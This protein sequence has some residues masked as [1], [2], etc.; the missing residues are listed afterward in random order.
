VPRFHKLNTLLEFNGT[1]NLPQLVIW[2]R[3]SLLKKM[4]KVGYNPDKR[5]II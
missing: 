1:P 3:V 5:W 2:K 4:I